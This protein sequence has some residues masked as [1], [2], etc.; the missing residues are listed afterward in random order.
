MPTM[1]SA[2]WQGTPSLVQGGVKVSRNPVEVGVAD[3][4]SAVGAG[5]IASAVALGPPSASPRN[6]TR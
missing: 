6:V 2:R 1:W 3:T 5:H 4:Q